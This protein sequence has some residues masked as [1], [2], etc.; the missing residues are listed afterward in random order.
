[1]AMEGLNLV[2][3]FKLVGDRDCRVC[4]AT[5]IKIDG[6]GGLT[7]YHGRNSREETIDLAALQSL[8]I[9]SMVCTGRA[10]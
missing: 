10:A 6:R 9:R 2:L 8:S 3:S 1:M 5:R 7:L 4:S